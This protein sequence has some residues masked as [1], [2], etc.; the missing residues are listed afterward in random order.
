MAIDYD[1]LF[2]EVDRDKTAAQVR[3]FFERQYPKFKR[4]AET[5]TTALKSPMS[6]G[7]PKSPNFT[8]TAENNIIRQ[9]T[10]ETIVCNVH[11]AVDGCDAMSKK[12]IKGCY[13]RHVSNANMQ[14]L[15]GY[16]HTRYN[17]LKTEALNQFADAFDKYDHFYDLHVYK[18]GN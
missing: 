15:I 14:T 11:K 2:P 17:E 10:A 6:D 9:L 4:Y 5:D 16:E 3:T 13:F 8:N 7:Q 12:I 1:K 18:S